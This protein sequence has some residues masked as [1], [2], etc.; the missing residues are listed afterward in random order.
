MR[1]AVIRAKGEPFFLEERDEPEP[2]PGEIRIA[3][4]ACG[5][6]H[7]DAMIKEGQL[8]GLRFPRVP[9]H[10]AAGRVDAVGEGVSRW[11]VGDRVGVGWHGGHCFECDHC[12]RGDFINC[13][14]GKVTGA[15]HDGGYA[16]AMVVPAESAARIPDELD[17]VHAGPLLCAG[18][19]TFNALRNAGL[20]A[21][22]TV[23]VQGIGGLGH[24]GVQFARRMGCRTVAI[25]RGED[26]KSLA[27]ELGAHE[28]IDAKADDPA[29]ALQALGGAD[30]IL[31]TA[32]HGDAIESVFGGLSKRGRLLV[33]A[34]TGEK[35]AFPG[36][37]LLSGKSVAGWPSG[38]AA[39]SEDTMR[40]AAAQGVE[41]AC[42]TFPLEQAN[43]A[44]AK[45]MDNEVRFR[46]VLTMD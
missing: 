29:K 16:T 3:V 22:A 18:V 34:A 39:D 45:M 44:Y 1:A 19:T 25:S 41:A 37:A 30:V 14:N 31:A 17:A 28:F 26:K 20:R 24:L 13:D 8:P 10:E 36:F 42:E 5:V 6:C 21:G 43:E 7:S 38:T 15:T 27:E 2:G 35:L 4:E 12:R 33:V 9:G 46:A 32:P 23:A 40:F 11:A